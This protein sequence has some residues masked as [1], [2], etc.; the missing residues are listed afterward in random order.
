MFHHNE[1]QAFMNAKFNDPEDF[2]FLHSEARKLK[3]LDRKRNHEIIE[4]NEAKI[5]QKQA[6][7]KRQKDKMAKKAAEIA[8]IRLI[9]DRDAVVKLAGEKLKNHFDAFKAAGAPNIQNIAKRERVAQI[10]EALQQAVDLY[11]EGKWDPYKGSVDE[12]E[13]ESDGGEVFNLADIEEDEEEEWED[14]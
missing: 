5:A 1:T 13:E 3:G 4:Y 10:R 7:A 8:K 9:L 11:N 2:R 12:E 14:V 6:A